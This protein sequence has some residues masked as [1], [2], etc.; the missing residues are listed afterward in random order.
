MRHSSGIYTQSYKKYCHTE[1]YSSRESVLEEALTRRFLESLQVL[2]HGLAPEV[3]KSAPA[4]VI[5]T[6]TGY[7]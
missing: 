7:K 1:F 3:V 4:N 5:L 6:P 2:V